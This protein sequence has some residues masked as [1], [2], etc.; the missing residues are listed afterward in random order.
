MMTELTSKSFAVWYGILAL[1][2][3]TALAAVPSRATGKESFPAP[4]GAVNDFAH[5]LQPEYAEKM[6]NL[7]RELLEKTG[8]SVVVATVETIGDNDPADYANRLYQAWGIGK[9]GEDKGVLIF[10]SQRAESKD[11]DRLR[12]GL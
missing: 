10:L 8:T 11:R 12:R 7:A 2:I 4:R 6:E 1:F 9:K 3:V 5:V